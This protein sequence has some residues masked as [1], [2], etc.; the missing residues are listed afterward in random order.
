MIN[1]SS[2]TS[3]LHTKKTSCVSLPA[4]FSRTSEKLHRC[5]H[6]R[7]AAR[8][9]VSLKIKRDQE[10]S[11]WCD[12]PSSRHSRA[13]HVNQGGLWWASCQSGRSSFAHSCCEVVT[14]SGRC[15]LSVFDKLFGEEITVQKN[16]LNTLR[17]WWFAS[18]F[19]PL[20]LRKINSLKTGIVAP[21][22][23]LVSVHVWFD[24]QMF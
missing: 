16:R 10:F 3:S 4:L 11:F 22:N 6:G 18:L 17:V 9:L 8:R 20:L 5:I 21:V 24:K 7:W 12:A 15:V 2:P 19:L 13:G 23:L 1:P 14:R